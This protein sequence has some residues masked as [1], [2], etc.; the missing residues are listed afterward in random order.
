VETDASIMDGTTQRVG[1]VAAVPDLGNAVALARAVLDAGEH[2]MLAGTAAWRFAAELGIRPAPAGSLITDRMRARLASCLAERS[3]PTS[4]GT[5]GAV[6]RDRAG[7]Y[8]AATST[9]GIVGKRA[10]RVGDSPVPGAGT[11]AD[12]RCAISATG[13]GEAILRVALSR[14]IAM[15]LAAGLALRD[16][17]AESLRELCAITGGSAG[18]IAVDDHGV[19]GLQLS[20][21]MPIASVVRGDA[22]A[23][24]DSMGE[25]IA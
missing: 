4:G 17:I 10:G 25:Q 18:V 6:A 7:R 2:V 19:L 20:K 3:K 24:A 16:A 22:I 8:A 23:V 1:A 11:W 13:D 15:R 12:A 21:T 9:G 5:V 14:S